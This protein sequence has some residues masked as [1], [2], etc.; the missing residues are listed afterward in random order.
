MACDTPVLERDGPSCARVQVRSYGHG[1][2]VHQP[3]TRNID[4]RKDRPFSPNRIPSTFEDPT[5][6]EVCAEPAAII[7]FNGGIVNT[8]S[9][10]TLYARTKCSACWTL[11]IVK[12]QSPWKQG[13]RALIQGSTEAHA[14]HSKELVAT[15][16]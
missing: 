6:H 15:S 4:V 2:C 7:P 16:L 10:S 14:P 13:L 5:I 1:P 8:C 9:V 12:P 3:L 11:Q